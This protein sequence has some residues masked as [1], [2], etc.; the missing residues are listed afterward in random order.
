MT[1]MLNSKQK[2]FLKETFCRSKD[3]YLDYVIDQLEPRLTYSPEL[4][5]SPDENI[6]ELDI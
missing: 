5:S 1:K 4:I 3:E 2:R 6:V